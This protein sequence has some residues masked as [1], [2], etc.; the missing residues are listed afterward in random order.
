MRGRFDVTKLIKKKGTNLLSVIV[1]LPNQR[2]HPE[3]KFANLASPTYLSSAGWDWMPYV[4]GLNTGITDNVYLTFTQDV[5][6]Q[7]P[8]IRTK[9]HNRAEFAEVEISTEIENCSSR[10]VVVELSGMITPGN[11]M[12]RKEL[13]LEADTVQT[14][15]LDGRVIKELRIKEPRLWWPN[16]MGDAN[17]Y[18]CKLAIAV[19]GRISDE[20]QITF[21]IRE[22]TYRTDENGVF[23]IYVN[24]KRT[25]L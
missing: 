7:D 21:G 3:E 16:G 25:F 17:L 4:P 8:W 14:I 20:K 23:N 5:T 18:E 1:S 12:F 13:L 10:K 11:I 24:G 2:R 9:L 22:Y 15:I 6:L 19:N